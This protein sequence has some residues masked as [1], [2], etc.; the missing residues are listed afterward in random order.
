MAV[1]AVALVV[2]SGIVNAVLL[3]DSPTALIATT[4]GRLLVAKILLVLGVIAL[5]GL[6]RQVLMPRIAESSGVRGAR[7]LVRSVA[8]E[9][10]LGVAVLAI[11][12]AL[13]TVSPEH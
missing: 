13:G 5:G 3:L 1:I 10:G 7:G 11:V 6:N 9:I 8:V 4:Y 12:G 2:S